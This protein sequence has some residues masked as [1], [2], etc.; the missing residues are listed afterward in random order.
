MKPGRYDIEIYQGG[1]FSEVWT[2]TDS[3]GTAINVT[4]YSA[5]MDIRTSDGTLL[6]DVGASGTLALG[7][8][9]GTVTV[10]IPATVT[11][12]LTPGHYGWDIFLTSPGGVATP[13]L[14]GRC[15]VVARRTS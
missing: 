13:L 9:A 3:S 8:S 11:D 12:D 2:W 1:T 4:G 14:A 15:E 7:G 10:T 5:A 6:I